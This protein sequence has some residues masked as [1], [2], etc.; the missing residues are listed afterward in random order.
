VNPGSDLE[1]LQHLV[2]LDSKTKRATPIA[3]AKRR[4]IVTPDMD[5]LLALLA[6]EPKAGSD[7]AAA[8]VKTEQ[9]V[10]TEAGLQAMQL[11][12]ED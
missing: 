7:E 3:E 4:F 9:G 2:H 1:F 11:I 8:G 6:A 5:R 10:K 12:D